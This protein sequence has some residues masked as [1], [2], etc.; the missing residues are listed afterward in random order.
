MHCCYSYLVLVFSPGIIN[1]L[2]TVSLVVHIVAVVFSL[3][4]AIMNDKCKIFVF[5]I[6]G[7]FCFSHT[8]Y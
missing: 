6:I 7:V 2:T 1:R 4:A 5:L 3:T 8:Q